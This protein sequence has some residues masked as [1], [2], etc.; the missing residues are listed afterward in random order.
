M[1]PTRHVLLLQ[2]LLWHWP[3]QWPPQPLPQ[4]FTHTL[5][6]TPEH[7]EL[8]QPT[9]QSP[10]QPLVQLVKHQPSHEWVGL[11]VLVE[12]V[13]WHVVAQLRSQLEPHELEKK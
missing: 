9:P 5:A 10:K 11:K 2:S 7:P 4:E 13:E 3:P 6:H 12:H 8:P 1:H